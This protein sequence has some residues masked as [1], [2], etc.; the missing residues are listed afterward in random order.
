MKQV[1]SY[2][3]TLIYMCTCI[4]ADNNEMY[5]MLMYAEINT[6]LS[7]GHTSAMQGLNLFSIIAHV[8][9]CVPSFQTA[10]MQ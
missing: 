5:C 9:A 3:E 2:Y 8:P 10:K 7:N 1:L 6:L 4:C